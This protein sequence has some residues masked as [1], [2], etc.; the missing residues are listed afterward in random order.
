MR[1]SPGG[2]ALIKELVD[3]E[4]WDFSDKVRQFLN[5]GE[6]ALEDLESCVLT[7][8]VR[9]R[10]KDDDGEAVDGNKYTIVGRGVSGL[11]FYVVGKILRGEESHYFFFITARVRRV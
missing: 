9:K 1:G 6:Y 7:G 4:S 5:Q 10:E 8:S 3:A 11:P 2:L